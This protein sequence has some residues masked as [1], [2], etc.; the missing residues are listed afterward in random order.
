MR[1]KSLIFALVVLIIDQIVKI[2]VDNVLA[3]NDLKP[4]IPNFFYL[5]KVYNDG[6]AWSLLSGSTV[7]L[8][9]IAIIALLFLL[10]YQKSFQSNKRNILAFALIYGGLVGNLLDRLVYGYVIDYFKLLLGSYNFPVFNLADMAIVLGVVL[11]IY[12][13]IKGEDKNEDSSRK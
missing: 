8:I 4:I 1:K 6:A 7:I 11:I 2:I 3:F 9:V 13:V 10:Y 5:T 12:A